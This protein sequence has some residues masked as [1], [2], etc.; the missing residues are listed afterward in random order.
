VIAHLN[1][2]L[3]PR[4]I[5]LGE[6][7]QRISERVQCEKAAEHQSVF[8][9]AESKSCYGEADKCERGGFGNRSERNARVGAE[10]TTKD[11]LRGKSLVVA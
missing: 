10:H 4:F 2:S 8:A 9:S 6:A 7:L 5:D 11:W 3:R 1:K